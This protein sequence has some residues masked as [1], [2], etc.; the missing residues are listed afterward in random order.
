LFLLLTCQDSIGSPT[1]MTAS[2]SLKPEASTNILAVSDSN[3]EIQSKEN[4]L[5]GNVPVEVG[6]QWEP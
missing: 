1:P 6:D 3:L 5:E 4:D 2:R